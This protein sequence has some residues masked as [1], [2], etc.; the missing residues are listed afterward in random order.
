MNFGDDLKERQIKS[1]KPSMLRRTYSDD[2][3][4]REETQ[5]KEII[6]NEIIACRHK[7]LKFIASKLIIP[8]HLRGNMIDDK[9][10]DLEFVNRPQKRFD[11]RLPVDYS[12]P[13]SFPIPL[14]KVS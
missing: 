13:I 2:D 5:A 12:Q 3:L 7:L 11:F 4:L 10:S 8:K 9:L 6:K 14:P 1:L